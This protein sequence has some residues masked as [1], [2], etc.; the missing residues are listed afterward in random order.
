MAH[1]AW[2]E[3]GERTH[4][5]QHQRRKQI[6]APVLAHVACDQAGQG[7]GSAPS[8]RKGLLQGTN[9]RVESPEASRPMFLV[10]SKRIGFSGD[11]GLRWGWTQKPVAAVWSRA[12]GFSAVDRQL[13]S[14][15]F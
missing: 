4:R 3:D 5:R 11:S 8:W 15:Q 6:G 9:S 10:S 12:K 1:M 13:W 14:G 7:H 2:N